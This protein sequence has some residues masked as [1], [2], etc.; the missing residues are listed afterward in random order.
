ML[1]KIC[2]ITNVDDAMCAT[3]LGADALGFIF[4]SSSP[5]YVQLSHAAKIIHIVKG[6]YGTK[7]PLCVGVFVN[8]DR[9]RISEVLQRVPLDCLQFHGDEQANDLKGYTQTVWKAFRVSEYFEAEVVKQYPIDV[10][11]LDT[12]DP[13][14]FGGTGKAF[15]WEKAVE[16]K[17][18]RKVILSGGLH[19][20]NVLQAYEQVQP[21]GIDVNSGV[22]FAPGKKD[23]QKLRL[24]FKI[25]ERG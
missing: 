5:R 10:C 24:L 18:Y 13:L 2:G 15:N 20:G 19:P 21:F 3:E 17:K 4:V 8:A 12:Y 9:I 22:E 16:V 14:S 6:C 23:H 11:V 7:A 1:V 25:M